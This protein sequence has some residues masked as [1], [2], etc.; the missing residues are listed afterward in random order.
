MLGKFNRF[1]SFQGILLNS[2]QVIIYSKLEP[3]LDSLPMLLFFLIYCSTLHQN[4]LTSAQAS[5]SFFLSLIFLYFTPIC[6][7]KISSWLLQSCLSRLPWWESYLSSHS[8]KHSFVILHLNKWNTVS[9]QSAELRKLEVALKILSVMLPQFVHFHLR[10]RVP[11]LPFS[12]Q[13]ILALSLGKT[14]YWLC[15]SISTQI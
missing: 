15:T 10:T 9:H 12:P 7:F 2:P 8:S 11:M 3:A 4:S 14:P 6:L 1:I 5:A 13:P